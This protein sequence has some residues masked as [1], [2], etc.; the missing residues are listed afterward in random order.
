[1]LN[2]HV[3]PVEHVVAG[4]GVSIAYQG[5]GQG[6]PVL[7]IPTIG[8]P[9]RLEEETT[10]SSATLGAKLQ[11][12][13]TF[14]SWEQRGIGLSDQTPTDF[15]M[16]AWVQD[17][18]A[19]AEALGPPVP[20]YGRTL[21]GPV[22]VTLAA[23]RP[24]LVSGLVLVDTGACAEEFLQIDRFR[25]ILALLDIKFELMVEY[26]ARVVLRLQDPVASAVVAMF[27]DEVDPAVMKEAFAAVPQHDARDIAGTVEVPTLIVEHAGIH[28]GTLSLTRELSRLIPG[29]RLI[30]ARDLDS[31]AEQIVS[32]LFDADMDADHAHGAFR[33]IMF[34]DLVSS[35]ALTQRVGDEAAQQILNTHDT[36]VRDALDAH[37]GVEVKHTGDGIMAAFDSATDAARAARQIVAGLNQQ[38]VAVRI[39]LN[40]GEPIQR[41]GDLFGTAV[42]IAARVSDAADGSQILATAVVRDLTAGKG[43]NWSQAPTVNAKGLHDP[44]PV[45]SLDLD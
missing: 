28:Y 15:S 32:F 33:T 11:N 4:D 26:V 45:F 36:A 41:D 23:K 18:A 5:I 29:A 12:S 25:A 20:V 40:A 19:V 14:V 13:C 10:T 24:D 34:T 9:L 8:F 21:S 22:A 27:R 7:V 3:G 31:A 17:A 44:V 38:N 1:M 39:G 16:N 30:R 43:L 35:T 6:P 37:N 42:Q 2:S